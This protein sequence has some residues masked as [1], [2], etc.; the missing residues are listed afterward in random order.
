MYVVR[1]LAQQVHKPNLTTVGNSV[2]QRSGLGLWIGLSDGSK[3]STSEWARWD[4]YQ[5]IKVLAGDF[6]GDGKTDVMKFDVPSSGISQSGLWV[7]LSDGSK[8]NTSEWARWDTYQEIKVLAGD[9]NGDGKTDVMK[10]DVPSSGTSQSGLWV[11]LSDGSKFNTSEWARWDTYQEIKVLAGDFNGDGKT[12]VMKFDVPSSGTSQSGLWVGLSDGSKFNTSEWARW[13]TYQEIKV[14]AGDFNGDDKTDVMKF[15]VPSAEPRVETGLV[16][17]SRPATGRV[18]AWPLQGIY[19]TPTSQTSTG[20][21]SSGLWASDPNLS[22][23][24]IASVTTTDNAIIVTW[25]DSNTTQTSYIIC[26]NNCSETSAI[27]IDDRNARSAW[28]VAIPYYNGG[29]FSSLLIPGADYTF[30]VRASSGSGISSGGNPFPVTLF[31]PTI[32]IGNPSSGS[33][34]SP[35]AQQAF[36]IWD[37]NNNGIVDAAQGSGGAFPFFPSSMGAQPVVRAGNEFDR[38]ASGLRANIV[39]GYFFD[40]SNERQFVAFHLFID[41]ATNLVTPISVLYGNT[42]F[43]VSGKLVW[44]GGIQQS[45]VNVVNGDPNIIEGTVTAP[46]LASD[47]SMRIVEFT[48]RLAL[49]AE[50]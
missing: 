29:W 23:P 14:L 36:A 3:F 30:E 43:D 12:D 33:V 37:F 13:D 49:F 35:V 11:G 46:T 26:F 2:T 25:T 50:Q 9:F 1:R 38:S 40:E 19:P 5:E 8:F 48:F 41:P 17:T 24:T 28:F 34:S 21:S 44:V 6:N 10:F 42:Q 20:T 22:A 16:S 27:R 45:S 15:D 4:T 32:R 47:S 39:V 7:G 18:V 31:A